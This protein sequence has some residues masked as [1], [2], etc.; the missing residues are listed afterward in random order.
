MRTTT[1]ELALFSSTTGLSAVEKT[2][3]R[4]RTGRNVCE[5]GARGRQN[6]VPTLTSR[7]A[8]GQA[9]AL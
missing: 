8:E 3:A 9:S 2:G 5:E 6:T 4:G 1:G 7:S